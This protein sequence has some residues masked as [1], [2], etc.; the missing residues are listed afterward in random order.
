MEPPATPTATPPAPTAPPDPDNPLAV[1]EPGEQQICEIKR[2]P[3]GL[4]GTYIAAGFLLLVLAVLVFVLAPHIFKNASSG[5]VVVVGGLV[6]VAGAAVVAGFL[7]V[8]RKV[9]WSNRWIVTSDSI[10]Q[11]RRTSLFDKQ[12]SQLSLGDLEDIT[13]EQDGP[14][15]Q[16][17]HFGVISAETAGAKDK[18]TFPY[19]PR[20][21]EYAKQILGARERF[22]AARQRGDTSPAAGPSSPSVS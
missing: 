19:C 20:P 18:F 15:A 7:F 14:L 13:A 16:A 21:T 22:E 10:T 5:R 12:T 3:I 6:F 8:A 4:I 11:V 17:L 9:Y 1:D 2:H